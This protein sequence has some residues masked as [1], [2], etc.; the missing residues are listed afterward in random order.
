MS[1][2][3]EE[4]LSIWKELRQLCSRGGFKLTSWIRNFRT[5]LAAI[6]FEARDKEGKVL[7]FESDALPVER[8]LGVEWF[9]QSDAF[10]FKIALR[11]RP[12]TKRGGSVYDPLGFSGSNWSLC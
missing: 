4:A 1:I 7:D 3:S 6:P 10:K 12:L 8:D 11:N 5:V 2:A 9:V